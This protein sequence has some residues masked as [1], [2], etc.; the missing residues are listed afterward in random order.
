MSTRTPPRQLPSSNQL[1]VLLAGLGA[2]L[3]GCS[4]TANPPADPKT[5]S[6]EVTK[7]SIKA[8]DAPELAIFMQAKQHFKHGMYTTAKERFDTLKNSFPD[9]AYS[10]YA[11]IKAADAQFESTNYTEAAAAYE[12]FFKAHPTSPSATYALF[13]QGR[14]QQVSSR[15][16]GRD[17]APLEKAVT[18]YSQIIEQFSTSPYAKLAAQYKNDALS[19]LAAHDELIA[20][21]YERRDEHAAA[22]G[23]IE[24]G[25]K[26]LVQRTN[27]GEV[28]T[29]LASLAPRNSARE[30]G[31]VPAPIVQA[32]RLL[33]Q[34]ADDAGGNQ[35]EHE[36]IVDEVSAPVVMARRIP[37]RGGL[38]SSKTPVQLSAPTLR[39]ARIAAP[40]SGI[41]GAD[42][43][44]A[45][46]LV[47]LQCAPRPDRAVYLSMSRPISHATYVSGIK[48]MPSAAHAMALQLP[49]TLSRPRSLTCGAT[50]VSVDQNGLVSMQPVGRVEAIALASPPRL[51]LVFQ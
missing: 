32:K 11:Q 2:A 38:P 30:T 47:D 10:E 40:P 24:E 44:A 9:G 1:Y 21:F 27:S 34:D 14:S 13:R 46:Q 45:F 31:P 7:A 23:R 25:S 50:S 17:P 36:D 16:A 6:H 8:A 15:G 29:V 41:E 35:I 43:D 4:T 20:Q 48:R 22:A 19:T 12:E 37:Q 33:A 51:V 18:I 49:E 5:E 3:I 26:K 28:E 42:D 39:A